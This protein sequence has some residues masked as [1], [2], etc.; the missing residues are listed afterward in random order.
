MEKNGIKNLLAPP[1]VLG[2]IC[3]VTTLLLSVGNAVTKDKI[4]Q[5]AQQKYDEGCATVLSADTYEQ[6]T[7]IPEN[8]QVSDNVTS[9]VIAKD[10]EGNT[11]GACVEMSLKGYKEGLNILVGVDTNRAVTGVYLMSH[12]ETPGLGANAAKPQFL[13]QFV[14]KTAGV[15]VLVGGGQADNA[16]DAITGATVTSR[17]IT[18]G[19]NKAIEFSDSLLGVEIDE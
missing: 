14:G 2:A 19:V 9:A 1:V 15:E 11:L 4:A 12:Q 13:S 17:A 5:I 3:L 16:I 18:N 10:S 7:N 8:I 6:V